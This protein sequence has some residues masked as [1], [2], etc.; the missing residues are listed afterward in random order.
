MLTIP[1]EVKPIMK[2]GHAASSYY[3]NPD[4]TKTSCCASCIGITPDASIT[5]TT[6]Q[7]DLD[8]RTAQCPYCKRTQP[9]DTWLAFFEHRPTKDT[10]SYYCGCRGWD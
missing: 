7:R 6:T 3:V 10:D 8:G 4:G 2:C 9:S 1:G 5:T